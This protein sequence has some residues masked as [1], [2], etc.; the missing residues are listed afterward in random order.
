MK[1]L[2]DNFVKKKGIKTCKTYKTWNDLDGTV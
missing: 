1:K 2:K